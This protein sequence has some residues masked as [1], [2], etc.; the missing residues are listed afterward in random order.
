M[1]K[2][3]K[4]KP[5]GVPS[6]LCRWV[7]IDISVQLSSGHGIRVGSDRAPAA[8]HCTKG[9]ANAEARRLAQLNPGK[10]FAA[11]EC[12]SITQAT[13]AAAQTRAPAPGDFLPPEKPF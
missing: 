13:V 5:L 1:P 4:K 11:F 8:L 2:A 3:S 6:S 10:V 9:E 7:I 12:I